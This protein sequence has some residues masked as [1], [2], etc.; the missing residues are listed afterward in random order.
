[1]ID[2]NFGW[3]LNPEFDKFGEEGIARRQSAMTDVIS[4][5]SNSCSKTSSLIKPVAPVKMTFMNVFL[6]CN[7]D[8]KTPVV[9]NGESVSGDD[10]RY[11]LCKLLLPRRGKAR[12]SLPNGNNGLISGQGEID[13]IRSMYIRTCKRNHCYDHIVLP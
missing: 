3:L 1:M 6:S 7:E 12:G 2:L 4:G 9:G 11:V 10:D 8:L 5:C 13:G